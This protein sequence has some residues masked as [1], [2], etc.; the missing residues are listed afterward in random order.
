MRYWLKVQRA[1]LSFQRAW[2]CYWS[3]CKL[4][5]YRAARLAQGIIIFVIII[6]YY[7]IFDNITY[8]STYTT[9]FYVQKAPSY[10]CDEDE[11]W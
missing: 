11:A 4:K 8:Q 5:R 9:L 7:N 10:Y 2:D 3:V 1:A 6:K